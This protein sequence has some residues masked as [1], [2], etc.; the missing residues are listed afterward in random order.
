MANTKNMA[1]NLIYRMA[2]IRILA[3]GAFK[4]FVK[5]FLAYR[6]LDIS[7]CCLV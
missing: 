5:Q 4:K 7:L 2:S 3:H 6:Y 1:E